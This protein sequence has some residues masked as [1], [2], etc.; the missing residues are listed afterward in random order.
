MNRAL[1]GKWL[2]RFADESDTQ[3]QNFIRIKNGMKAGGGSPCRPEAAL[4][5][6]LKRNSLRI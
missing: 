1:L 3:W 6:R 4:G 5:Q 2:W